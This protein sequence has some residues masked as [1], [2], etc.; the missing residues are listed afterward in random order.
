FFRSWSFFY[1]QRSRGHA[2]PRR[3]QR[4]ATLGIGRFGP[5]VEDLS[6]EEEKIIRNPGE[7]R[8]TARRRA[9]AE[10]RIEHLCPPLNARGRAGRPRIEDLHR[11]MHHRLAM[12]KTVNCGFGLC[13]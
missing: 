12:T 11:R 7:H 8:R 9:A 10:P 6:L 3:D 13:E 1:T 2:R 4:L 5:R